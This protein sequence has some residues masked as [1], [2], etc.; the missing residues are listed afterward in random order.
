MRRRGRLVFAAAFLAPSVVLYFGFVLWPLVRAFALSLY[1]TRGLS[2]KKEFIGLSNYK[3]LLSDPIFKTAITNNLKLLA[4][5]V[6]AVTIIGLLLAHI[7]ER[8]GLLPRAM[9]SVYLFPHILSIVVVGI[10]WQF[11]LH[12]SIGII[13]ATVDRL[14]WKDQPTWLGDPLT[15]LPAVGVAFIWYSV[16]FYI[17]LFTAALKGISADVF[18]AAEL[19]GA[20]G[21]FRFRAITWPLIWSIRR[22]VV[23]H[24]SIAALNTFA[25]VR[26][27]TNGG[28]FRSSEV[29]LTYL[30]EQGFQP[31]S[32]YGYA[33]T[34]AVVNFLVVMLVS[35][36]IMLVFRRDPTAVR[37]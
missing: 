15:A 10:L 18:E 27:M 6:V 19:D 16:G 25:L 31:N 17:M 33:T 12:P 29:T 5:A 28:P 21:F 2:D 9:R 20:R 1:Q 37:A 30:Y 13:T 32:F 36:A 35:G 4:M 26:M 3:E 14:G 8:K 34:I 23:I 22:V 7:V 24:A 11:L